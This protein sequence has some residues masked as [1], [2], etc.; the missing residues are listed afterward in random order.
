MTIKS[1]SCSISIYYATLTASI[2]ALSATAVTWYYC[3]VKTE[4]IRD[5]LN[6]Q[7]MSE[8]TG[9]IRSEIR[10]RTLLKEV[11][12]REDQLIPQT[13]LATGKLSDENVSLKLKCIGTVISPFTKRM[14]TPRQG[15]VAPHSRGYVQLIPS[16]VQ[17]DTLSGVDLFSHVW[18]IFG[19]HAN[20]DIPG[21]VKAKVRPPRAGGLKV[22]QM[23]TRSP[24]RPNPIGL[25]LVRVVEIDQK[26]KRLHISALDLVNGTPVYG[27]IMFFTFVLLCTPQSYF[28]TYFCFNR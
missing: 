21:S 24:H 5:K 2:A 9:R 19:F 15:A 27:M 10:L 26:K 16:I 13:K 17:M 7:R 8:R 11:K 4:R 20:T 28:S 18:I 12:E 6:E 3:R 1:S 23:A 22:G 25:S 14:G